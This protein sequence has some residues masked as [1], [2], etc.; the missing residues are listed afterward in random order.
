MKKRIQRKIEDLREQPEHIRFRTAS[1]MT[2]I[3]GVV[4]VLIWLL[5]LLPIQLRLN[6]EEPENNI[7]TDN[8][9]LDTATFFQTPTPQVG[10]AQDLQFNTVPTPESPLP[11]TPSATPEAS[12]NPLP[13][14]E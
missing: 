14:S 7:V 1:Y 11:I 5:I 13:L 10:G 4:I 2:I 12:T 8:T 9:Q 3:G 6:R